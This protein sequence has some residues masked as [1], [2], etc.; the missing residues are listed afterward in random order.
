EA[1]VK[2][3][4][5]TLPEGVAL[6]PAAADGLLACSEGQVALDSPDLGSCPEG[7]KVATVEIDSP[8]LPEPLVGAAYLAEQN[9]N[10][11]GSLV[12]LY[13]VVEDPKAGVVVKV[14][15][16]VKPDPV[17][18]QLVST[19]ANT[20]QLPFEDLRLHFFGGDRAPLATPG[21]CGP[22]TTTA[23]IAPWSGNEPVDSSSTFDV[24]SGPN[25][26]AC[27]NPLLFTPELTAGTTN[28][29]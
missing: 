24:T 19:F 11:F 14:A 27:R 1:S 23:S 17:T 15:G 5:V 12:A 7:S 22:Y 28:I 4:T 26:S 6:N 16:E 18:G 20:P 3:T 8:L 25:G 29:Q 21:L 13:L 10:P 2:D 9:A